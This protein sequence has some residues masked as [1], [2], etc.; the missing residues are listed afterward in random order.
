[1][2]HDGAPAVEAA[3]EVASA[4]VQAL[5]LAGRDLFLGIQLRRPGLRSLLISG[6][7]CGGA[8]VLSKALAAAMSPSM[9]AAQV[10]VG[11]WFPA[12]Y[13]QDLDS[14]CGSE[15]APP[16][17]AIALRIFDDPARMP[18]LGYVRERV[19][20]Q[21]ETECLLLST[22]DFLG[23]HYSRAL[24]AS[25]DGVVLVAQ[26]GATRERSLRQARASLADLGATLLGSVFLERALH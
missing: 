9:A 7:D 20:R 1:L 11:S 14:E 2:D 17:P 24:A 22:D 16:E 3:P 15:K 10:H 25:V 21:I 18:D 19:L 6:V 4:R 5:A 23:N 8:E 13:R 12:S 26:A